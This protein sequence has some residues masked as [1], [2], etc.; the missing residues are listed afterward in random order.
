[1]YASP[2]PTGFV[3]AAPLL[4]LAVYCD[5]HTADAEG[6]PDASPRGDP[7]AL[8][9]SKDHRHYSYQIGRAII[10]STASINLL[11]NERPQASLAR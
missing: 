5:L 2:D 1:M 4:T 11:T 7:P 10:A 8:L 6:W 3:H 9:W